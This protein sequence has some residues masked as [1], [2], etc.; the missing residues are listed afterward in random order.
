MGAIKR[1]VRC[2]SGAI[3]V[4]VSFFVKRFTTVGSSATVP[5]RIF[6]H[7]SARDGKV[8]DGEQARRPANDKFHSQLSGEKHGM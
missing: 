2:N 1:E 7:C 8:F 4:A 5:H 3:P 6:C